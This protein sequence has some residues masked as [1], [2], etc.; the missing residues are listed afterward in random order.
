M[1]VLPLPP[2][3]NQRLVP[4]NGRLVK[5]AKNR[6]YHKDL[7]KLKWGRLLEKDLS[8]SLVIY[9]P[10]NRGDIDGRL[11]TLFDALSGLLYKD[12]KQIVEMHVFNKTDPKNPRVELIYEEL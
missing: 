7:A 6:Q 2:T 3:S 9:R 11:K 5:A 10:Q 4:I 12:D 1:I 8:L